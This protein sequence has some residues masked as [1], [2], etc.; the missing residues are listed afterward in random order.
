MSKLRVSLDI[1]SIFSPYTMAAAFSALHQGEVYELCIPS[2]A[3]FIEVWNSPKLLMPLTFNLERDQEK[4]FID[5]S[6]FFGFPQDSVSSSDPFAGMLLLHKAIKKGE[7][8]FIDTK[9]YNEEIIVKHAQST[10]FNDFYSKN[11]PNG[12]VTLNPDMGNSTLEG[13]IGW[14]I[15][16]GVRPIFGDHEFLVHFA[17]RSAE[18]K[19]GTIVAKGFSDPVLECLTTMPL[20]T[21]VELL[22]KFAS[23]PD[24]YKVAQQLVAATSSNSKPLMH[25]DYA[26]QILLEIGALCVDHASHTIFAGGASLLYKVW[27]A[28]F[29]KHTSR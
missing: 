16:E 20:I 27:R 13:L 9:K 7:V 29:S 24:F 17:N 10:V 11:T 28:R 12:P 1:E 26:T 22:Y 4:D 8:V 15:N 5:A 23:D 25:N 6:K 19:L 3:K 21:S 14:G 2:T 18:I